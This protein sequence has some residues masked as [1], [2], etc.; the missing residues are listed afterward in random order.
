MQ[1]HPAT[2]AMLK[3]RTDLKLAEE[4]LVAT[5]KAAFPQGA[6]VRFSYRRANDTHSFFATVTGHGGTGYYCGYITIKNNATGKSRS[7]HAAFH[8]EQGELAVVA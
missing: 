2:K 3:A 1:N 5:T 4:K 6:Q 8:V 7:I